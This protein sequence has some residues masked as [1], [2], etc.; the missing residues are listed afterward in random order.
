MTGELV[1]KS[2]YRNSSCSRLYP[3]SYAEKHNFFQDDKV[4][5][6]IE[7]DLGFYIT[8]QEFE[9]IQDN[10]EVLEEY[11][12]FASVDVDKLNEKGVDDIE[13]PDWW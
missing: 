7:D 11:Q 6:V 4:G 1:A 13:L 3:F 10:S 8:A 12:S 9:D 2:F 5:E